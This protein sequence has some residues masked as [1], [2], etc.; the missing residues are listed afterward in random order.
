MIL[1]YQFGFFV[2]KLLKIT[3]YYSKYIALMYITLRPKFNF[4]ILKFI[5]RYIFYTRMYI[6]KLLI[7]FLVK[8]KMFNLLSYLL[9]FNLSKIK[10]ILPPKKTKQTE[11]KFFSH[12]LSQQKK[13]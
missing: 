7:P 5:F 6:N 3:I 4:K 10:K 2:E 11:S 1:K 8:F 12:I 9:I 13:P